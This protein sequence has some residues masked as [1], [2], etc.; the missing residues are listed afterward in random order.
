MR[1]SRKIKRLLAAAIVAGGL[2]A[3]VGITIN[4]HAEESGAT[5]CDECPFPSD[6]V[7][8]P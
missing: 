6:V 1:L 5:V 3:G 7:M 8:A 2:A 4:A